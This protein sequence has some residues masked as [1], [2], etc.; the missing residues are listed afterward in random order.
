MKLAKLALC[1]LIA[2][3]AFGAVSPSRRGWGPDAAGAVPYSRDRVRPVDGPE[4]KRLLAAQ[5]GKVV[6]LNFWATWCAPCVVEFP[7]IVAIEAAHRERGLVVLS[8]SADSP[9]E[10]DSEVIP[11][12]N[13]H[14]PAFPI[15]LMQTN[16]IEGF[17]KSV[18]AEWEGAIPATFFYDREGKLKEK[19]LGITN[20]KDMEH[21][22]EVIFGPARP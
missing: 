19:R 21:V 7:D 9:Q 22:L 5:K 20:R 1:S 18:D 8:V 12:L 2:A 15:Y 16:D 10:I 14:E 3:L 6:L 4:L 17:L 13:K 11:F